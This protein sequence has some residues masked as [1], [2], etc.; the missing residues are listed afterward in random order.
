VQA[1][2]AVQLRPAHLRQDNDAFTPLDHILT[3]LFL[4]VA[5]KRSPRPAHLDWLL[6]DKVA[7]VSVGRDLHV[8]KGDMQRSRVTVDQLVRVCIM[9]HYVWHAKVKSH[10]DALFAC[11]CQL[12]C[13]CIIML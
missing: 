13:L 9:M 4:H 1:A 5:R 12:V 8:V 6:H 10:N 3:T 7:I 11:D 2:A